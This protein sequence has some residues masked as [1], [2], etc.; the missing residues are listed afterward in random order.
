VPLPDH[1]LPTVN[2]QNTPKEFRKHWTNIS[3][4]DVY[5]PL[6][7]RVSTSV[8][9]TAAVI[10]MSQIR[11]YTR[12][13]EAQWMAV[14][15]LIRG[16]PRWRGVLIF[17]PRDG[18]PFVAHPLTSTIIRFETDEPFRRGY[19]ADLE[20]RDPATDLIVD[21]ADMGRLRGALRAALAPGDF[22][23]ATISMPACALE[24][25]GRREPGHVPLVEQLT[26]RSLVAG[27][28]NIVKIE[29][30]SRWHRGVVDDLSPAERQA[31]SSAL[32]NAELST[33]VPD[34][35]WP[36]ETL[37][38]VYRKGARRPTSLHVLSDTQLGLAGERPAL[39]TFEA[40]ALAFLRRYLEPA[41]QRE[42]RELDAQRRCEAW[43]ELSEIV[44]VSGE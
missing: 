43:P 39:L 25:A 14:T 34:T 13:R 7:R 18:L 23:P 26:A 1:P 33:A 9:G 10:F 32:A 30:W 19:V 29:V 15:N 8:T 27:R 44:R 31:L 3:R 36:D 40:G 42:A 35:P 11:F 20:S 22:C 4:I 6:L 5:D 24:Q 17:H 16:A 12:M 2:A 38:L 21:Q 37:L 41:E 28:R